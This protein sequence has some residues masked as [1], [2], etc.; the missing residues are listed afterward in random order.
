MTFVEKLTLVSSFA[1]LVSA[2]AA[3]FTSIAQVF[4]ARV[5]TCMLIDLNPTSSF[6]MPKSKPTSSSSKP[7]TAA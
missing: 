4:I 3:L 2:A 5:L 6:F 1:A 7:L